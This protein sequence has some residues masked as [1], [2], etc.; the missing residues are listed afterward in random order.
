MTQNNL[1]NVLQVL[2]QRSGDAAILQRAVD[3]F[4]AALTV[5]TREAAPVDWAMTQ[6]NLGAVLRVLG[7][8]SSDAA[9]LQRAVAAHEASL[10]MFESVGHTAYA[11]I[12]RRNRDRAQAALDRLRGG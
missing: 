3:A 8:R 6:N 4:E 5:Y 9:I 7:Q 12:A 11:D 2:G 1:G 10:A